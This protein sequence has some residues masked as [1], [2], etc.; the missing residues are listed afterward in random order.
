ME[1]T[2]MLSRFTLLALIL[3]SQK[4]GA[5]EQG[6]RTRQAQ[7]RGD[8]TRARFQLEGLED[9]SLLSSISTITEFSVPSV[10]TAVTD[11]IAKGPDANLWFTESASSAIGMI[12]PTTHAISSFATPTASSNPQ[13]ITAGPDGNL[14]FTE[15]SAGKVGVIN[16]TTHAISEFSV[17]KVKGVVARPMAI[18]AGA[19]GNLWFTES[20]MSGRIGEINPTTHIVSQFPISQPGSASSAGYGIT[21]GPDGNIWFTWAFLV[22]LNLSTHA[23]TF[24]SGQYGDNP[25]GLVTGPDRNLWFSDYNGT[26]AIGMFDPTTHAQSIFPTPN[27]SPWGITTGPDGNLWFADQRGQIGQINPTTG[28]I[29]EYP[30]PYANSSPQGITTGPDGNL[31]FTDA[32]TNAVGVA[33][34]SSSAPAI[35][36]AGPGRTLQVSSS[37][38]GSAVTN[39]INVTKTG[40]SP[41]PLFATAGYTAPDPLLAPLV[42]DSPD[43]WDNVRPKRRSRGA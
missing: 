19:D 23:M 22:Q 28:A 17:P 8:R 3:R 2:T 31:W 40:N 6:R 25:D 26:E 12:N 10:G 30:V 37:G 29:T 13:G 11:A 1:T 24:Y 34:L 20:W 15:Y 39:A 35:E 38:L 27:A 33:T 14:W 9:R 5:V 18:T 43:L 36:Q 32:G 7:R 42:L 41:S 4:G 21:A 16:L